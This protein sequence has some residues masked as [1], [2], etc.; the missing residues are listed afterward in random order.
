[1]SPL[2]V[3]LHYYVPDVQGNRVNS[4]S[5]GNMCDNIAPSQIS[6][7]NISVKYKWSDNI[8]PSQISQ[9]NIPVKYKWI[10]PRQAGHF[11]VSAFRDK[12]RRQLYVCFRN[13]CWKAHRLDMEKWEDILVAVYM[14]HH[15]FLWFY[16][17]SNGRIGCKYSVWYCYCIVILLPHF[18]ALY[19]ESTMS[20]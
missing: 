10:L 16:E 12:K 19:K 18:I 5:L 15:V 2:N 13:K 4:F 6:R 1:M 8:A 3:R 20:K 17:R 9:S 11:C 7:S 14:H